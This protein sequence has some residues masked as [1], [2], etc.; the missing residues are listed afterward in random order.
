MAMSCI[1]DRSIIGQALGRSIDYILRKRRSDNSYGSILETALALQAINAGGRR[2]LLNKDY[3]TSLLWLAK[4]SQFGKSSFDNIEV[5]THVLIALH[6]S[7]LLSIRNVVGVS[8]QM[9]TLLLKIDKR[10]SY[11]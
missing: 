10:L 4:R 8:G 5:A 6:S 9:Q 11:E 3:D 2:Y 1:G 7:N